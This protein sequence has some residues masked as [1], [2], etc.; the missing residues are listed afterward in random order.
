MEVWYD[1]CIYKT[2]ECF[3]TVSFRQPKRLY[4]VSLAWPISRNPPHPG[5][6]LYMQYRDFLN[7]VVLLY[8]KNTNMV[9]EKLIRWEICCARSSASPAPLNVAQ[10]MVHQGAGSLAL[11][12]QPAQVRAP[13]DKTQTPVLPSTPN[14]PTALCVVKEPAALAWYPL[15]ATPGREKVRLYPQ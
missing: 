5:Q 4:N 11:C 6:N 12:P 10:N 7:Y 13:D 2:A 15:E 3:A 1:F 8:S 14:T 9:I